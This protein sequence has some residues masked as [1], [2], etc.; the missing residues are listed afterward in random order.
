[1]HLSF[2]SFSFATTFFAPL[3][4]EKDGCPKRTPH[5]QDLKESEL[6]QLA[7]RRIMPVPEPPTDVGS[8]DVPIKLLLPPRTAP[9]RREIDPEQNGPARFSMDRTA[10]RPACLDILEGPAEPGCREDIAPLGS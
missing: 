1:M 4:V 10:I 6:T 8:G 7:N 2:F 9:Q 5:P 3:G